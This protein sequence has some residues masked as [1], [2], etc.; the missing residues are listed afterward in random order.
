M[1][2]TAPLLP[3]QLTPFIGRVRELASLRKLLPQSRLLTLT[4]AGGS[5]KTRLAS[6][7]VRGLSEGMAIHWVELASLADPPLVP[8]DVLRAVVPSSEGGSAATERLVD[9]LRGAP[10]LVVLDNCEHLVDACAELANRLLRACPEL[11]ILATSREALGVPGERAW[12]VPPLNLPQSEDVDARTAEEVQRIEQ[13][14]AVQLFTDRAQDA[15]PDFAITADNAA[16]VA[17]ICRQLDGIPLAIELAAS[18]VRLMTPEQIRDRLGDAFALLTSRSRTALPR[19]RTLRTAIDWSHDLLPEPAR[20]MLRRLSVFRG[21]FTLEAVE[22]V[23]ALDGVDEVEALDILAV[24]VDRSMVA[25]REQRGTARYHLLET[26]RQYGEQHLRDAGEADRLQVALKDFISGLVE[27]AEPSFITRRRREVFERIDPEI[28]NIR[29]VLQ[30]TRGNEPATHVRL[31]GMLWWYWFSTQHWTEARR[32]IDGAL[33]L[34]QA[35]PQQRERAALLFASGALFTLQGLTEEARAQ[36]TEALHTAGKLGDAQLE[37]YV[38]NYLSMGYSAEGSPN[39]I[40]YAV[41]AERYFRAAGDMY[42]LRLALLLKGMGESHRG[43]HTSAEPPLQEAV[44]IARDFGQGRELAIALQTYAGTLMHM[45]RAAEAESHLVEALH[46]LRDDASYLFIARAADFLALAAAD[47]DPVHSIRRLGW[48]N[49]L[50]SQVGAVRFP[51]DEVRIQQL[52]LRLRENTGDEEFE[53]LHD[54]AAGMTAGVALL[55]LHG[56]DATETE[57]SAGATVAP[58]V[59]AASAVADGPDTG[60][61]LVDAEL[62]G[63]PMTIRLLGSVRVVVRG[64]PVQS[65]AYGKPRELLAFL[66]LTPRGRTRTEISAALWPDAAPAQLRN[67]FH[68]TMHHLRKTLGDASLVVLDG[69][70]YRIAADS[71]FVCDVPLFEKAGRAASDESAL[72]AALDLYAGDFMEGEVAGAWRDDE[73]DRLRRLYVECSLRLGALLEERGDSSGAEHVYER[74]I[75]RDSLTEE[76]HRRLMRLWT[77]GGD[78]VRALRQYERL[79]DVLQRTL[80]VDPDDATTELYDEVRGAAHRPGNGE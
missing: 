78:R 79:R 51:A 11:R 71:R 50:R 2:A 72:R 25:V 62:A 67:N 68:V 15:V 64:E 35:V 6:E 44:A 42:G 63:A 36:L 57:A 56:G 23:A 24:L 31:V 70:R 22:R 21:G 59:V 46:A 49:V 55:R 28:D 54:E 41:R 32:W 18:R 53:R 20:I 12:L 9:A 13:S 19:H 14:D 5:G 29:E 47:R 74:V 61:G 39:C 33:A 7:L 26:I 69:D 1:S 75:A 60:A 17:A 38:L 58:A 52:M 43:D 4:G 27:A 77:R 37:A 73:Q 34:P 8:A 45:G 76:P 48:A 40:E 30:W 80:G 65:W 66:A 16:A 3:L 10:A